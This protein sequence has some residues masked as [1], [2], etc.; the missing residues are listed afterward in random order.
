MQVSGEIYESN[1]IQYKDHNTYVIVKNGELFFYKSLLFLSFKKLRSFVN[2]IKKSV[3][4]FFK[5]KLNDAA[6]GSF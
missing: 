4:G 1:F 3:I 2:M 5:I 6:K